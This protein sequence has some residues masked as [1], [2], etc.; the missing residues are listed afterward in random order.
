[1]FGLGTKE[2]ILIAI[3]LILLFGIRRLPELSRGIA[4]AARTFKGLFSSN[5][6]K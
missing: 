1:M 6:R 5:S 3:V 2:I 4:E